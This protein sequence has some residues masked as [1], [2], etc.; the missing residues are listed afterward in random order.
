V[1]AGSVWDELEHVVGNTVL[2]LATDRHIGA[3]CSLRFVWALHLLASLCADASTAP[4]ALAWLS[5]VGKENKSKRYLPTGP[6]ALLTDRLASALAARDAGSGTKEAARTFLEALLD[7]PHAQAAGVQLAARVLKLAPSAAP[8]A[9]DLLQVFV[10]RP[11]TRAHTP[12]ALAALDAISPCSPRWLRQ[13]A[14]ELR[15]RD[16]RFLHSMPVVR[17]LLRTDVQPLMPYLSGIILIP[18]SMPSASSG[19]AHEEGDDDEDSAGGAPDTGAQHADLS[20]AWCLQPQL[21]PLLRRL[22]ATQQASVAEHVS[23]LLLTGAASKAQA[24]RARHSGLAQLAHLPDAPLASLQRVLSGEHSQVAVRDDYLRQLEKGVRSS[25]PGPRLDL[26]PDL[27][28]RPLRHAF[29]CLH[30]KL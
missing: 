11:A 19:R 13:H 17:A 24:W 30:S 9:L 25:A 22:P 7:A 23:R 10:S 5:S 16:A 2:T 14:A 3:S 12:G 26:L 18:A 6:G 8:A 28:V 29:R 21:A 4:F 20:N 1:Q 27:L 15:E